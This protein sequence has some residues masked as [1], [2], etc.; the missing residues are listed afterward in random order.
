MNR[1]VKLPKYNSLG[2]P[3]RWFGLA[4]GNSFYC[5]CE[6]SQKPWFEDRAVIVASNSDKIAIAL[7]RKAKSLGFKM[8]DLLFEKVKEIREHRVLIYPSNYELYGKISGDMHT[9]LA[10]FVTDYEVSSIDEGY[11]DFTGFDEYVDLYEY[12]QEIIDTIRYGKWIPIALGIA[13]TKTLAKVA[14]K[15]AKK[16]GSDRKGF[17]LIAT[18][19][20]RIEALRKTAL[21]DVWGIGNATYNK[22][23]WELGRWNGVTAYD[24]AVMNRKRVRKLLGVV[25]ERMWMELN[26]IQCYGFELEPEDKKQIRSSRMLTPTVTEYDQV[27]AAL[28][29]HL[30][31]TVGK[32]RRQRSYARKMFIYFMTS[33][34]EDYKGPKAVRSMEVRFSSPLN[35]VSEIL[36]YLT[37]AA[38]SV[39]PDYRSWQFKYKFSKC[40]VELK[41]ISPDCAKQPCFG[42]DVERSLKLQD[43][44]QAIDE[45]NGDSPADKRTIL[46]G[47]ELAGR[48]KVEFVREGLSDNPTGVWKHRHKI[49]NT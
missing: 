21:D 36:P 23:T 28:T 38:E 42:E 22:L 15:L 33:Q 12:G 7:N 16:A 26:G 49:R 9:A 1:S 47:P 35:T 48:G 29:H 11:M 20:E 37:S 25:G 2:L 18:E 13:P 34:H 30:V 27:L 43:L 5:S 44:Q 10:S 6:I 24:F 46:F 3:I 8:G 32:L 40:G 4:D 39:W 14:N 45:I 17:Y 19:Q 41:E 31:T